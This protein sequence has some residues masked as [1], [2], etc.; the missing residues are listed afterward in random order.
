MDE[1]IFFKVVLAHSD[2]S[3]GYVEFIVKAEYAKQALIYVETFKKGRV[4]SI[5][6]TE[7]F[8]F[9]NVPKHYLEPECKGEKR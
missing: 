7:Y 6:P 9:I 3:G 5:E 1:Y 8:D 4:V 2:Y